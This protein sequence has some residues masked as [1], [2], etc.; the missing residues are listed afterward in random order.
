ML[1]KRRRFAARRKAVGFSQEQLAESL[2][3][4]R[5][6]VGRWESGETEPQPWVR[7]KLAKVLQVSVDELNNLLTEPGAADN[8]AGRLKYALAH[9]ASPD[10]VTV[11][12][13][14]QQLNQLAAQSFL[15]PPT[16]LLSN[17]CHSL[18]PV[19]FPL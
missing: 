9:P 16:L 19:A 14:R 7:P 1:V 15:V 10:L 11:A 8:E 12:H 17:P 2:R 18:P 5:S 4:D 3:I 13:L 6:T